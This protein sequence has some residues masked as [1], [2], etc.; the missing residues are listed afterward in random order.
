[1]QARR[2]KLSVTIGGHDATSYVDPTLL[3]F[4]YTDNASGKSDEIQ[5]TLHDREGRWN[6]EWRPSKGTEV[7]ASLSVL[8]W[9]GQGENASLN[10]GTFKIDE[11]EFI[12]PPDKVRIKAV[13]ASLTGSLRDEKRTKAWESHSLRGIAEEVASKEGLTLHYD[14]QEH[15]FQRRVQREESN[16]AF[17][18][19][20]GKECGMNVKVHDEKLILFAAANA[21]KKTPSLIITKSGGQFSPASYSF[22]EKSAGTAYGSCVVMYKD[23]KSGQLLKYIYPPDGKKEQTINT[24]GT[25]TKKKK[26]SKV[27]NVNKRVENVKQANALAQ[28][29]LRNANGPE[30]TAN[31]EIMGPPGLVAVI[32]WP[33]YGTGLL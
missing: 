7:K 28:S 30:V 13:S 1:M 14:G 31:I 18:D 25:H 17:V 5:L 8:D 4:E 24:E 2:T 23:P 6:N 11:L 3:D 12:G 27:L 29:S 19:R 26:G 33:L 22:K 32:T 10:C 16:L 15:Q 9:F 20:L 21:D